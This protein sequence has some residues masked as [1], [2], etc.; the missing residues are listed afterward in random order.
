MSARMLKYRISAGQEQTTVAMR[1]PSTIRAISVQRPREI[2]LWAEG[3]AESPVTMRTFEVV[4]TGGDIPDPGSYVGTVFDGPF[5]W[6]V[7]EV[8]S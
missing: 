5:V 6:H 7:Y 1:S 2:C 3:R 4:P 8:A